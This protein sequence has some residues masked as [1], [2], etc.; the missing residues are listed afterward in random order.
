MVLSKRKARKVIEE[1][2]ALYP[3]AQ[4]S[5]HFHTTFELLIAVMLSA[6]TTDAAVNKVTPALFKAFPTPQE[7]SQASI[8]ELEG[9]ISRLGLYR[10]KARFMQI[11]SQQLV[12]RYQGQ[13]P[14]TREELEALAGV[15]RKTANV[16]LSVGFGIPAFAVDTHVS[17]ICKHHEI[18]AQTATPL[19]IE[20]RVMEVLPRKEWLAAH[21]AMILFGREVCHPR[22][23]ECSQFP[24]LY[25]LK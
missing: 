14:Q 11:C 1:I 18:V 21:Q 19:Q 10:N 25:H 13:V 2:I 23:P 3:D 22:N 17:R 12:D 16:V 7:M 24:Q 5:L 4:P 9:Y 15:G 8:K 6:Q 20:Q